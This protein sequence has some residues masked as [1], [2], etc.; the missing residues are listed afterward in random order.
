MNYHNLYS[1][2]QLG[3]SGG[4]DRIY[5]GSNYQRGKG[6]VGSFLAGLFRRVLPLLRSGAKGVGKE[7]LCTGAHIIS[8]IAMRN[9]P[10][11][12]SV[13]NRKQESA[14][15][16]KRKVEENL[17]N[18]MMGSGY[19]KQRRVVLSHSSPGSGA[20][21][22]EKRRTTTKRKSK[23]KKKKKGITGGRSVRQKKKI[24]TARDIFG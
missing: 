1:V 20:R 14:N 18:L 17:D 24:R 4:I 9:I 16:L 5:V 10:V 15:N 12:E 21:K 13:R 3:R 6:G 8:D 11:N 2:N 7:A 19:K 23:L 22:S